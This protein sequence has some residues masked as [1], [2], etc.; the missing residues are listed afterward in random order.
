MFMICGDTKLGGISSERFVSGWTTSASPLASVLD[1]HCP[2]F[3]PTSIPSSSLHLSAPS[4]PIISQ[5]VEQCLQETVI[6]VPVGLGAIE[7]IAVVAV[8]AVLFALVLV[9]PIQSLV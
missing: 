6:S 5:H 3:Y 8:Q 7:P 1:L 9:D 4:L 2:P